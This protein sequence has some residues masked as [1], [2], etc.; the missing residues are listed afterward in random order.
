[1]AAND[2]RR[3]ALL[4]YFMAVTLLAVPL[5][6]Y[7]WF[8][9]RNFHQAADAASNAGAYC[10]D[11]WVSGSVGSGTCSHHGGVKY[12]GIDLRLGWL[13]YNLVLFLFLVIG[14]FGGLYYVFYKTSHALH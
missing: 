14:T 7:L 9:Y 12:W 3:A 6:L 2:K 8:D 5:S 1:V 13:R 11:G 10:R 4:A